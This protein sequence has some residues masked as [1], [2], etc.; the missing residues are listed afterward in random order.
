MATT[1]NKKSKTRIEIDLEKVESFAAVGCTIEQ[2]AIN[3]GISDR[4]I[5]NRMAE[6]KKAGEDAERA[7]ISGAIARGKMKGITAIENSLFKAAQEDWRAASFWLCNRAPDKWQ[8]MNKIEMT[9]KD[10]SPLNTPQ[11][12][13]LVG[14]I[15][16]SG[17]D[18]A[19]A[20]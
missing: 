20:N 7:G 8:S 6:E 10:G 5:Y 18:S 2:I 4:T 14:R 1:V 9:G 19:E 12:I 13:Q 3:L 17:T 15:D 11:V 16:D